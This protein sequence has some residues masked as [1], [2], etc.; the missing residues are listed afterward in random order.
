MRPSTNN[1]TLKQPISVITN[2]QNRGQYS[3]SGANKASN[4]KQKKKSFYSSV[5]PILFLRRIKKAIKKRKHRD[6]IL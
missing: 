4:E 2:T 5:L 6:K 3:S 1:N